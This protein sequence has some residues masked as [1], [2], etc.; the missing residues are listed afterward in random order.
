[1]ISLTSP[2]LF[3]QAEIAVQTHLGEWF[4]DPQLGSEL[5]KVNTMKVT[6]E[7]F[8][9]LHAGLKHCVAHLPLEVEAWVE[10]GEF[11]YRLSSLED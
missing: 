9:Q 8:R 10:A 3:Q 6:R 4:G 1:M 11:R 7:N 5:H 2:S